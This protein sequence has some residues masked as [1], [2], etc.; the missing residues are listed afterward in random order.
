[1][2]EDTATKK[3][4]EAPILLGK[5]TYHRPEIRFY[6]ALHLLTQ[7]SSGPKVDGGTPA[8]RT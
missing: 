2:K 3:T 5:K 6:G 1:M 4:D 7:G 8:A